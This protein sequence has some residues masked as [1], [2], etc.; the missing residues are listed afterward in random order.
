M[1]N[2]HSHLIFEENKALKKDNRELTATIYGLY[3]KIKDLNKQI[4]YLKSKIADQEDQ[5]ELFSME[6]LK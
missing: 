1:T 6:K 2:T 3:S 5:L 4:E